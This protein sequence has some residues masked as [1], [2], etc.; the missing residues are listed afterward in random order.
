MT[1][2]TNLERLRELTARL[3]GL[4][5][6][7]Q[8]RMGGMTVL[9]AEGGQVFVFEILATDGI[10][11]LHVFMP[12]GTKLGMHRHPARYEMGV[13]SD[14]QIY[15]ELW[16]KDGTILRKTLSYGH[17]FYALPDQEHRVKAIED[18]WVAMLLAPY[19]LG[20]KVGQ[21]DF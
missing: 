11:M 3:P 16:A 21:H 5:D 10:K 20:G 14:G 13:V 1:Q 12:K 7:E 19:P 2:E 15:V 9:E 4:D 8:A 18:S 17:S 6:I